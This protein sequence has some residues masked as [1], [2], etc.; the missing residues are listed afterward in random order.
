MSKVYGPAYDAKG[1]S[2]LKLGTSK[3]VGSF[4]FAVPEDITSVTIFVAKY[5]ANDTKV[6]V[7]G[8]NTTLTKNSND[9]AYDEI[10]IDT[11]TTK[12]I[13]FATVATTYRCMIN[14]IVFSK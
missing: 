5:K 9:G 6:S 14:T 13:S 7:N 12:T 3:L 4:S 2:C 8:T 11:T 1:N 10:V